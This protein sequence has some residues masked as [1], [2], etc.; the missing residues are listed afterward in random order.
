MAPLRK[1]LLPV[2][3]LSCLLR[4]SSSSAACEGGDTAGCEAHMSGLI[5]RLQEMKVEMESKQ[6]TL[7]ALEE[8]RT[9]I[10]SGKRMELPSAQRMHLERGSSV[11]SQ[12]TFDARHRPVSTNMTRHFKLLSTVGDHAEARHFGFMPTKKGSGG[13]G[14]K[15]GTGTLLAVIDSLM[16]LSVYDLQGEDLLRNFDLGHSGEIAHMSLPT[17]G[18]SNFILTSDAEGNVRVH[19]LKIGSR[20]ADGESSSKDSKKVMSVSANMTSSFSMPAPA[21]GS[22]ARTLNTIVAI[23]KN[24]QPWFVAGDSA[25]GISVFHKNGTFKGR[26]KVTEDPGGVKGLVRSA[27]QSMLFY[28]SHSFGYFSSS[29]IEVSQPPCT[30]WNSPLHDLIIDPTNAGARVILALED[31]DVLVFT[32]SSGKSKT[33]DLTLK[34][35]H[36]S[37]LPFKLQG[38]RGQVLGIPVPSE[39]TQAEA[40]GAARDLFVFNLMAMDAG[41]GVGPSKAVALQASFQPLNPSNMVATTASVGAQERSK[42]H[43]AIRFEGKKGVQIFEVNMKQPSAAKAAA[44]AA[45]GGAGGDAAGGGAESWLSWLDWFPKIGIFGVALMGVVFWNVRKVTNSGARG[46]GGGSGVGGFGGRGGGGGG[47][48]GM[49]DF[50]EQMF[51]E[52]LRERREKRLAEQAAGLAGAAGGGGGGLGLG[53]QDD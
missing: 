8:L 6:L 24:A 28:S 11:I 33:C 3:S 42:G 48:A 51:K 21:L 39:E 35:P 47:L 22:E 5:G 27:G 19:D 36:V 23:E 9:G 37:G 4:A 20:K 45:G 17:A 7:S 52:R 46:G 26:V 49:D 40:K 30:G 41:Y 18:E 25:G 31:G 10:I 50:D 34:F 13:S 53:G 2:L 44:A 15:A 16:T 29:Q 32:T 1:A 14:G 12:V 38:F 43:A